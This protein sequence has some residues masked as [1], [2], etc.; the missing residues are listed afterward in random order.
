ML[1]SFANSSRPRLRTSSATSAYLFPMFTAVFLMVLCYTNA[2]PFSLS[3]SSSSRR[4]CGELNGLSHCE[5]KTEC[6]RITSNLC[7][8]CLDCK[9]MHIYVAPLNDVVGLR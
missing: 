3:E 4:V 9:G 5:L 8:H 2:A 1:Y 6:P 7:V